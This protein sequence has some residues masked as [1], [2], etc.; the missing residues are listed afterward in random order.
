MKRIILSLL[1]GVLVSGLANAQSEQVLQPTHIVGKRIDSSGVVT[2]TLD[3]DFSYAE[4]GKPY[5]FVFPGFAVSTSY[6]FDG[7]FL[8]NE[9]TWHQGGHPIFIESYNYT[10]VNGQV[11]TISHLWDQMNANEYWQYEYDDDGRLIQKDYRE[12]YEA[13]DFHQHYIYAYENDGLTKIESYWTSW[14]SEGLLLRKRTTYQYDED[15]RLVTRLTE[16]YSE[17]GVLTG[18]TMTTYSYTQSNKEE[19][20][21]TQTLIDGEWV[22][23]SIKSYIYNNSDRIVEQQSGTWQQD[24]GEWN[25]T[26]KIL[27]ELS[28]DELTYTVSFYKKDSNEWGWDVFYNQPIFFEPY[29]KIQ[30]NSMRHY[31]YEDMNGS[32][33]IN[34]FEITMEYTKMPSYWETS[35]NKEQNCS[36][37]PNPGNT[38][39][40]VRTPSENAVVRFYDLQGRML[41]AKPFNFQTNINTDCWAPGIY[42][43]EIWDGTQKQASGKW[44]KE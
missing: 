7:D 42:L 33:W 9:N 41:Q 18:S 21:I 23:T 8:T 22:N 4:N 16:N 34:Q 19:S 40:T 39:I 6:S 24:S 11:K 10:Y 35:D 44:I 29:L 37:F 26:K 14:P 28:T 25:I 13:G 32:G 43:W 38:S 5:R 17:A 27:F 2:T 30:Q 1:L 15:Y 12:G 20:E 31:G 36:V 3:S